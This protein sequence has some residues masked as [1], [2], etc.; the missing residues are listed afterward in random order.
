M[1]FI[2][3]LDGTK[4]PKG[5]DV[6]VSVLG[7]HRNPAEFPDP[8]KFD[9]DRFLPDQIER[10]H[11]FAFLPFTAGPRNCIGKKQ[12]IFLKNIKASAV[13]FR[14]IIPTGNLIKI[15]AL[16]RCE[17]E[18]GRRWKGGGGKENEGGG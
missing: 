10:R 3:I 6:H 18:G 17:G 9:P 13:Q 12:K 5:T 4:I 2:E 1:S 8:L 14:K 7:M 15:F 11:P 16:Q